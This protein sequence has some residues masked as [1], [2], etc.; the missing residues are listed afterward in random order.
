VA[1]KDRRVYVADGQ[2]GLQVV[3]LMLPAMPQIVGSFKTASP[4]RDV[5]VAGEFVLVALVSGKVQ[6][7]RE[8]MR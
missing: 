1:L 2:Q 3:D 8:Q 5:A 6:I 7:L 4:A